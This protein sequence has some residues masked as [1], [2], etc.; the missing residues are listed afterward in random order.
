[1]SLG[2]DLIP[3][4]TSERSGLAEARNRLNAGDPA[5]A[6]RLLGPVLERLV[7]Q[8][9][10][11]DQTLAA[12][13]WMVFS[14]AAIILDLP[15]EAEL[16][17][18]RPPWWH[19][20]DLQR[21][22]VLVWK[23]RFLRDGGRGL[24]QWVRDAAPVFDGIQ[25]ILAEHDLPAELWVIPLVESGLRHYAISRTKAVGLWQFMTNTARHVGLL[26]T[27]DRDERRDWMVSTHGAC[28]YLKELRASLG[29]GLLGL[30]A[31]NCGPGRARREIERAGS[32]NFWDLRLPPETRAYV[33]RILA[34]ISILG[35]GTTEPFVVDSA[36]GVSY[37]TVKLPYA[38]RIVDLARECGLSPAE[39]ERLNPSW[40][41]PVTPVDGNPVTARVPV[42][43]AGLIR[44]KLNDGKLPRVKLSPNRVYEIRRGD[45]L[46]DISQKFR[47]R[48]D[49]LLEINRLSGKE[50]IHPGR[51]IRI[52]G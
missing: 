26:V 10:G 47:V 14:L 16:L 52:P 4:P 42:G 48:L 39:L 6:Q 40:M 41:R 21:P 24:R 43:M 33:P 13:A 35:K 34:L 20:H 30:A 49:T 3:P 45:T 50:I 25:D 17:E 22:E 44:E 23:K 29:D 32:T 37:E 38:V 2:D 5:G 19:A 36:A 1:M 18:F 8:P 31:F 9:V 28:R 11:G 15:R 51:T 27:L 46:W 7:F 12:E